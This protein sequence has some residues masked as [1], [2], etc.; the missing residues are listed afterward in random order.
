MRFRLTNTLKEF[1]ASQ[2]FSGVLLIICTFFSL[3]MS[4]SGVGPEYI[5]FWE[6]GIGH[7]SITH[8][9]NDVLMAVFFLLV[10]LEIKRELVVGELST[11]QKASLPVTVAIGGMLV[12][13]IIY[14]LINRNTTTFSGWG[15]PMATDI[16]FALGFITLAGKRV[17]NSLKVLLVALAVVD[18]LGAILVIA[19]FY[20]SGIQII[21][22]IAAIVVFLVLLVLNKKKI[23]SLFPYLAGGILLW[24]F[25]YQSGIHATIAGVL[26]AFTIPMSDEEENSLLHK[27]EHALQKPVNNYIMPLF[28]LANTSIIIEGNISDMLSNTLAYGIIIGLLIGKPLGICAA[29]WLSVKTKLSVM[30]ENANW[31]G[32]LGMGFLGGI[33]FTMSI[34]I[35]LLAFDNNYTYTMEAKV[36]I[37]CASLVAG[38]IGF[39]LLK[40][41]RN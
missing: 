24:Y 39:L 1:I 25:V 23:T 18:D 19:A 35:S 9:I 6:A 5:R 11:F 32:I 2:Q 3:M 17:P 16:A 27:M 14:A 26:L 33:G 40:N 38:T 12:P 34:F 21:W 8:L 20:S 10:G 4:N 31:K 29:V 22:L 13:A 41:L 28:A 7:F 30:P 36:A 15:I 37:L